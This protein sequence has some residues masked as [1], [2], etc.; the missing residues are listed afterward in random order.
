MESLSPGVLFMLG[1]GGVSHTDN[2]FSIIDAVVRERYEPLSFQLAIDI[3]WELIAT[4]L[5]HVSPPATSVKTSRDN[6]NVKLTTVSAKYQFYYT[7]I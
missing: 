7:W 4:Q 2:Y 6:L 3:D 5:N 1:V